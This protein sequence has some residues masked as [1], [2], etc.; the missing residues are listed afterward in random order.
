M[1]RNNKFLYRTRSFCKTSQFRS[2][3]SRLGHKQGI[4][5]PMNLRPHLPWILTI[6]MLRKKRIKN[7]RKKPGTYESI[8]FLP[9]KIRWI[10][11]TSHRIGTGK[12]A[13]RNRR[14]GDESLK[15]VTTNNSINLLFPLLE[16]LVIKFHRDEMRKFDMR[17]GKRAPSDERRRIL[18]GCKLLDRERSSDTMIK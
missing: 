6:N 18:H 9:I 5:V 3:L 10:C 15:L 7:G 16:V 13:L 4:E 2:K 8:L 11:T 14:C 1:N 17:R 12:K